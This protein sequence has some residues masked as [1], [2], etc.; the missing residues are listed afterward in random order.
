MSF[1]PPKRPTSPPG[2]D[3]RAPI[4]AGGSWIDEAFLIAPRSCRRA[5]SCVEC[6]TA[7]QFTD[8]LQRWQ[9]RVQFRR[10]NGLTVLVSNRGI[11]PRQCL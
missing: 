1:E 5:A 3:V 8:C 10:Q 9:G 6:F 2:V 7:E 4:I 11:S